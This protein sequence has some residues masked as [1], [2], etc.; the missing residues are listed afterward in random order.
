MTEMSGRMH[1]KLL[2]GSH[3]QGAGLRG[4]RENR[5]LLDYLRIWALDSLFHNKRVVLYSLKR[6]KIKRNST[7]Y[8]GLELSALK[9]L[10]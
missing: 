10:V 7:Y 5:E 9:L 3:L 4:V 8:L 6:T 1:A 2:R